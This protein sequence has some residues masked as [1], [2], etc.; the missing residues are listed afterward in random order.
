MAIKITQGERFAFDMFADSDLVKLIPKRRLVILLGLN[1]DLWSGIR[2]FAAHTQRL[3]NFGCPEEPS[4]YHEYAAIWATGVDN[5]KLE[6]LMRSLRP[7][8]VIWSEPSAGRQRLTCVW[9]K[10]P[11]GNETR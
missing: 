6:T 8:D 2:V 7:N 3:L 4:I 5:D 1:D 10:S 11:A 9:W